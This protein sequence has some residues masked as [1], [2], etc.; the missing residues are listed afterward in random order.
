MVVAFLAQNIHYSGDSYWKGLATHLSNLCYGMLQEG[1]CILHVGWISQVENIVSTEGCNYP[2]F[3]SYSPAHLHTIHFDKDFN[4]L[5]ESHF[6]VSFYQLYGWVWSISEYQ[7]L[8]MWLS[9]QL[10]LSRC[11]AA[12]S[13]LHESQNLYR[14]TRCWSCR[15]LLDQFLMEILVDILEASLFLLLCR[16]WPMEHS[17]NKLKHLWHNTGKAVLE[18]LA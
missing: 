8:P 13:V 11:G 17:L 3:N 18:A 6:P 2:F 10:S 12:E 7:T 4:P 16:L 9:S 1:Q 15:P 5:P 14:D